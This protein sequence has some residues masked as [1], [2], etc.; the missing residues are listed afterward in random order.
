MTPQ[1]VMSDLVRIDANYEKYYAINTGSINKFST[2]VFASKN[3]IEYLASQ[4]QLNEGDYINMCQLALMTVAS[5]KYKL[6]N[7]VHQ[8][9][10]TFNVHTYINTDQEY[11]NDGT[12]KLIKLICL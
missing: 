4:A 12:K 3:T 9:E 11:L 1:L 7:D 6:L 10:H 5:F 8:G 2:A